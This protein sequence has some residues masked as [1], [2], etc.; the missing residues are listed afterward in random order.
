[1]K[2][3]IIN[4]HSNNFGDDA[5]GCALIK[6]LLKVTN[7]TD[8]DIIYH[9]T[10]E[11]PLNNEK[12]HHHLEINFSNVGKMKFIKYY[13]LDRPFKKKSS[14]NILN[15]WIDVIQKSDIVFFSPCGANIGIYRDWPS[16]VRILMV[17]KEKKKIVFHYNTIGKSGNFIF[18]HLA[19]YALSKS[20]IYVREKKSEEYIENIGLK[21]ICGPDTAFALESLKYKIKDDTISFIPSSFDAWHPEF[22]NNPV[23]DNIQSI[24]IPFLSSWAS[25][26]KFKIEILPH[27]NTSDEYTYNQ[28]ILNCF[29][30]SGF[31]DVIIR[32]DINNVWDY[33]RAIASSRIVIGLRYHA[34]VLAA[35]N[36]RPFLALCYENKMKE[37]CSYTNMVD[38]IIDIHNLVDYLK[39]G[40]IEYALN[41]LILYEKEISKKLEEKYISLHSLANAPVLD[42]CKL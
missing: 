4:Q 39:N 18:D 34:I 41:N 13:L 37:V 10:K 15:E 28:I 40:Q 25:K 8:I 32:T 17:I 31:K 14:S 35:K 6:M 19:K 11:I 16:L 1:M 36:C 20:K 30:K 9:S 7:V 38:S 12:V 3:L 42:N 21:C 2:V 26:N 27:L 33:D 23:D 5:A 22:K 24:F 29:I